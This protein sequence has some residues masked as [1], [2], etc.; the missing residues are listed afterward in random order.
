M[1]LGDMES[2]GIEVLRAMAW[3]RGQGELKSMLHTFYGSIEGN[4]EKF[5]KLL[6]EF[7]KEVEDNGLAE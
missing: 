1:G 2:R 6:R 3:E 4:F 5:D 7:V